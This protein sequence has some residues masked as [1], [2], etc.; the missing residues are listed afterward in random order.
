MCVCVYGITQK[1]RK[2][3][4]AQLVIILLETQ[5]ENPHSQLDEFWVGKLH[6]KVPFK[7]SM[8]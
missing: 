7:I 4:L 2:K 8:N 1:N 6:N 5:T 3:D